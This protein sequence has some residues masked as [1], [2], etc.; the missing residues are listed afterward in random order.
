MITFYGTGPMFG[1]PH[2][3]PFAIK[4]ELLLKM[5]DVPYQTA[6][7]DIRKAPRSKL[8]WIVDDGKIITDSRMIRHHLETNHGAEFSGGYDAARR[9]VGVAVERLF[10]D[11]LYWF[12]VDNRWLDPDNFRKGPERFFDAIPA[13]VRPLIKFKILRRLRAALYAQGTGRLEKDE[14]LHLVQTA[15][16]AISDIL[17]GNSYI[18]GSRPCGADATAYGFLASAE[19]QFFTSPYGEFIR[20]KPNLVSYL[21]RMEAEFFP[22]PAPQTTTA[23]PS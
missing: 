5:A 6:R 9:G 18:L 23:A 19:S 20:T 1:L 8:P 11:H 17:G 10:E 22:K 2:A 13:L 3:S 12:N 21:A 14:K 7:A 4:T 15:A 16:S